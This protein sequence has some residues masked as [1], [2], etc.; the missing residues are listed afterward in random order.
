MLPLP[1]AT[2]D[3][4]TAVQPHIPA[5]QPGPVVLVLIGNEMLDDGWLPGLQR[6]SIL[7]RTIPGIAQGGHRWALGSSCTAPSGLGEL[8]S[9]TVPRW[10]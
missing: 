1:H 9:L 2:P 5:A 3:S 8:F 7:M 10:P 4:P 6:V